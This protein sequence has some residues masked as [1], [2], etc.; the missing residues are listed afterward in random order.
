MDIKGIDKGKLYSKIKTAAPILQRIVQ[1]IIGFLLSRGIIFAEYAP[2]GLAWCA[3]GGA[4]GTI[5][6][7][8][9]YISIL[10][11]ANGLKY[12]AIC[13]LIYTAG[14]IFKDTEIIK[15]RL[16][17]PLAT[18]ICTASIGFVFVLESAEPIK[19]ALFYL[20]EVLIATLCCYFY[21][22]A[23]RAR[24]EQM[25]KIGVALLVATLILPLT[26]IK[27]F[28]LSLG[29]ISGITLIMIMGYFGGVGAGSAAGITLSFAMGGGHLSAIYGLSGLTSPFFKSRGQAFYLIAFFLISICAMLWVTMDVNY[30][31]IW[32]TVIAGGAFCAWVK[33]YGDKTKGLFTVKEQIPE[34]VKMRKYLEERIS[35]ASEAFT[36]L[37]RTFSGKK[38]EEKQ[39]LASVFDAPAS[40]VCKKCVLA[41][42]CWEREFVKTRGALDLVLEKI[43][44]KGKIEKEDF[45]THFSARCIKIDDFVRE[46]QNEFFKII[47]RKK[48]LAQTAK[49]R[50][51]LKKQYGEM[52]KIIAGLK[53]ELKLTFDEKIEAKIA[54]FFERN[55]ITAYPTVYRD[56]KNHIHIEIEGEYLNSLCCEE[57]AR[58]LS[59]YLGFKVTVPVFSP[60]SESLTLRQK[61]NLQ[62]YLGASFNKKRGNTVSGDAGSYYRTAEGNLALI[63]A[64]GMGSGKEASMASSNAI[65]M[66]ERFHRA[67]IDMKLSLSA[68]NTALTIKGE[69]TSS[70]TTID[71]M[72]LNLY[73]GRAKIYKLGSSPT[74]IRHSG[75]VRRI[76]GTSLPAGVPAPA[77]NTVEAYDVLVYPGDFLVFVT[78][79]VADAAEDGWLQDLILNY[80]GDS[81]RELA[82]EIIASASVKYEGADDMTAM[83][84]YVDKNN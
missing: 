41:Q 42:S 29:R 34:N 17:M 5:G 73:N 65:K 9:G 23:L 76:N 37:A 19:S 45:P 3:V 61:E 20:S 36:E 71:F 58:D 53:D 84:V 60:E 4:A 26:A 31:T 83:A 10:Y 68:I 39:T 55:E 49:S 38:T 16:F 48:H 47:Y 1:G 52:S 40:K 67:K 43:E 33:F 28:T 11:K 57:F 22:L 81:P 63:L 54:D 59:D 14:Y 74:Y 69:E 78:D 82:G 15:K 12:M 18:L 8:F 44:T 56:A 72:E 2:F 21:S 30:T 62:A 51:F 7:I 24:A 27:V 77:E 75:R 80:K 64:D 6:A 66:I 46:A 13:I 50:N 25:R 70:F 79:G 32:E 35:C